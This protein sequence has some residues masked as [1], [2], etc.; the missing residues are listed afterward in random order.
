M[1]ETLAIATACLAMN[2]YHE[3]RG[4]PRKGQVA[5]AYVTVNRAKKYNQ[6]VCSVVVA[7]KQ[8]SWVNGGKMYHDGKKW[9]IDPKMYPKDLVS[10]RE[11]KDVSFKVL[12]GQLKDPTKGSLF[13]H[14]DYVDPRWSKKM[15]KSV[16][17]GR[18][19][20]YRKPAPIQV[21]MK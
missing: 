10:W 8:F 15:N 1:V 7:D 13:Y 21:A 5:V 17:I 12:T 6:S 19:V 18:H 14:A 20:F 2:V 11:A 4:E 16:V 9:K 3:S